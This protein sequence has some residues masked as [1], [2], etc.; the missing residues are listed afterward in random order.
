VL[1]ERVYGFS[2]HDRHGAVFRNTI[3]KTRSWLGARGEIAWRD[4]RYFLVPSASPLVLPDP[5]TAPPVTDILLRAIAAAPRGIG[6]K[7][8]ASALNLPLRTVQA[9]LGELVA[10]GACASRREGNANLYQ[11][12]DTTFGE[13]TFTRLTPKTRG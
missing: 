11:M 4:G 9:H 3:T 8:V 13:P 12:E 5:R 2:Y 6:A 10:S 1:F 7:D